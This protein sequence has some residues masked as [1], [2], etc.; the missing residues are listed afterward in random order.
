MLPYY[1]P[2]TKQGTPLLVYE[3]QP[4]DD[5]PT[6]LVYEQILASMGYTDFNFVT[7]LMYAGKGSHINAHR[8][9]EQ[10]Y[11]FETAQDVIATFVFGSPRY[12][13]FSV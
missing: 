6:L 11:G 7:V 9:R 2:H 5:F 13:I 4:F 1:V 3:A 12:S 10:I 8:D